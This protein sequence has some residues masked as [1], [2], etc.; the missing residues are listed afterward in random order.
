MLLGVSVL[1]WRRFGRSGSP[2][3]DGVPA[4]AAM[5]LSDLKSI[6]AEGVSE[7]M[8]GRLQT[9]FDGYVDAEPVDLEA[10]DG[11]VATVVVQLREGIDHLRFSRGGM[12]REEGP[13]LAALLRRFVS[14]TSASGR[15]GE[16]VGT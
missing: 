7:E 13:A 8:G 12:G 16:E 2:E 5:A 15:K 9:V 10:V 4:P 14:L 1:L 6:E 3:A 11:E